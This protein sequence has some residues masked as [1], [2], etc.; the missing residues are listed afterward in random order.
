MSTG[1]GS[2]QEP[3]QISLGAT[4]RFGQPHHD[5]ELVATALL[6][7][8]FGSIEGSSDLASHVVVRQ[9]ELSRRGQQSEIESRFS[10]GPVV[11]HARQIGIAAQCLCHIL[12][13]SSQHLLIRM[14]HLK[15]DR[16]TGTRSDAVIDHQRLDT[17]EWRQEIVPG[18]R[19]LGRRDLALRRRDE[20]QFDGHQV[21]THLAG[22]HLLAH[23]LTK[24][25]VHRTQNLVRAAQVVDRQ[26]RRAFE[27]VSNP[28]HILLGRSEGESD[29]SG[30]PIPF[31][32]REEGEADRAA[33]NEAHREHQ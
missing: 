12:R 10:G 3:I 7:K 30:H 31:Q 29:R 16:R 27:L 23:S 2:N 21:A 26:A 32:R 8:R 18:L 24:T 19:Y 9:S 28:L 22:T 4:L 11:L 5:L 13:G 25:G 14:T 20:R 6:T 33:R 17:V 1:W 15:I